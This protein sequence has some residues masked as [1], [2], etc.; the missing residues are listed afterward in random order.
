MTTSGERELSPLVDS[1]SPLG[2]RASERFSGAKA[3][4][5]VPAMERDG[6]RRCGFKA[7]LV[8]GL[9]FGEGG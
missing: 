9:H 4:G 6:T 3:S 1:E 5:G 2:S 8:S 7:D